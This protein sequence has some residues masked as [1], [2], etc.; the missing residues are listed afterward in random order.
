MTQPMPEDFM[1][2]LATGM[3]QIHEAYRA[4]VDAGFNEEQAMSIITTMITAMMS[5]KG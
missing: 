2:A 1:T 5:G 4:A 3:V